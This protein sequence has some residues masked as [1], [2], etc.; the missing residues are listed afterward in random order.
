MCQALIDLICSSMPQVPVLFRAICHHVWETV[1]SRFPDS[2]HSSV[3]SFIFLRFLCPAIVS[4]ESVDLELPAGSKENRRGLLLITKIIQNLAN[5]VVFGNKEPH[6]KILNGFLSEN[7]RGV[8]KFLSDLAL[9]PRSADVAAAVKRFQA[10]SVT[11]QDPEADGALLHRFVYAHQAKLEG[12]LRVM[13]VS[14]GPADAT[15][16]S[17]S[18]ELDGR[19]ALQTLQDVIGAT[20][21]L[22]ETIRLSAAARLQAF[23]E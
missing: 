23:T 17:K 8:T 22:S 14:F 12:S 10:V 9:R 1:D 5:N 4:P 2:R 7:I 20:G 18:V 19:S 15:K 3:G 16:R 11:L 21:P 6:M 13:P